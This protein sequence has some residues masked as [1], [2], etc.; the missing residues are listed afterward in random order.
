MDFDALLEPLEGDSPSGTELRNDPQFHAIDRLLEPADKK[1]RVLDDGTLNPSAVPVDWSTITAD[2]F[3]L[4]KSGR[5]LRLINILIRTGVAEDSFEGLVTGL[6]MLDKTLETYWDSLHPA[7]RD[8]DQPQAQ[9][10]PRLNAIKQLEND[11]N[12]LLGDLKYS[13]ALSPRGIGPLTGADLAAATLS[14]H[15]A[16]QRYSGATEAELAEIASKH[17]ARVGRVTAGTRAL[18]AEEPER[19][20]ALVAALSAAQDHVTSICS[21]F[22]TAAG[23]TDGGLNLNEIVEF[24]GQVK[25]TLEASMSDMSAEDAPAESAATPAPSAASA[26]AAAGGAGGAIGAV[27]S[28]DDVERCL[29]AIIAFYDR[30]E[31]SNPIPHLAHRMRRMVRMDF[32]ELMEELAPS[33]MKE[34]RNVV[35]AE[36]A[37]GRK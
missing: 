21:R 37:K 14:V 1:Q 35:G 7:L 8:R 12:G 26:P 9:V 16:Q 13:I 2:G 27:N 19:A 20:E 17:E 4:A 29:D 28:R 18:A 5:D 22:N 11:D 24:L 33:G 34:F 30:T 23:L 32:M 6:A 36:D 25:T 15:D 3:E 10:Q 31:P